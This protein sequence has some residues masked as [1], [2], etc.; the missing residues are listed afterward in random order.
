MRQAFRTTLIDGNKRSAFLLGA[1][2][3]E[4]NDAL[5]TASEAATVEAV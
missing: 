2:F 5:F 4:L 3:L 1:L